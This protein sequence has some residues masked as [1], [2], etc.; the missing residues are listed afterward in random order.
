MTKEINSAGSLARFAMFESPCVDL[1]AEEL[2]DV[3]PRYCTFST[4]LA[5]WNLRAVG[6][7]VFH[8]VC[9]DEEHCLTCSPVMRSFGFSKELLSPQHIGR[10][11]IR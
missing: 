9:E 6:F 3:L 7:S 5:R 4:I 10:Q 8:V 11:V 1:E 2:L